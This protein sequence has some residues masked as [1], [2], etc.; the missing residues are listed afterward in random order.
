M[1]KRKALLSIVL[2]IVMAI[3][4]FT[5][6]VPGAC[7]KVQAEG[8]TY[9][10]ASE[11]NDYGTLNS[12]GTTVQI[13]G[14]RYDGTNV[15]DWYVIGYDSAGQTVTLLSKQS[16]GSQAFNSSPSNSYENSTIKGFVEGLIGDGKQLA[17]IKDAL[18]NISGKVTGTP[19]TIS[20]SVPYLLSY[21][22]AN[23]LNAT[24]K[25]GAADSW[26][27][28]S[29]GIYDSFAACVYGGIAVEYGFIVIVCLLFVP[30]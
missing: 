25:S 4:T 11:Y 7:L 3:S 6:F 18:A 23:D 19:D 21:A 20:G 9:S 17:G 1:K 8:T 5:G 12:N 30:L 29:P 28:R 22:E 2:T 15:A 16:F 14:V 13:E 24:K 27:L 10:P 26:W